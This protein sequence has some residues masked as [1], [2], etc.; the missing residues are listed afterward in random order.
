[1][2]LSSSLNAAMSCGK[3][4]FKKNYILQIEEIVIEELENFKTNVSKPTLNQ[5]ITLDKN[6]Q[7]KVLKKYEFST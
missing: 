3:I 6:I 7:R 4:I 2:A 5:I 1:M